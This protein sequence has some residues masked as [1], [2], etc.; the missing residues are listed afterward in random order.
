M[1]H[2]LFLAVLAVL[3]VPVLAQDPAKQEDVKLVM[4][5]K[6]ASVDAVLAYVSSKTGWIFVQEKRVS[7]TIEATSNTDVSVAS[8]LEILNTALARH[9][10]IILNPYSPR[11]PKPGEVLKVQDTDVGKRLNLEIHVGSDPDTIPIT[12]QMRTQ[13][14]PLKAVNVVEVN[15]E[16]G[17]TLRN[18]MGDGGSV[19]VTTYSNSM[20]LVGRSQGINRAVRILRV[21]DVSTSAELKIRVFPL[22]NADAA[23]TA[24]TLN[25]VFKKEAVQG[26]TGR[27]ADLGGIMRMFTGGGDGGGR[28]GRGGGSS[29]GA[30]GTRALAHE[31]VR[32]TA[33][34]RTNS[35]IVSATED[36]MKI[37]EDLI[38]KL[39]DK[40]A[41][42]VRLKLYPL[43][44]ADATAAAKLINDI[45]AETA[46][47]SSQNR[48]GRGGNQ[49][50]PIWMGGSP[51]GGS[52]DP[53]GATKEV[54]AVAEIRT[55]SVLVAASEE[56]LRIIDDLVR[57]IDRQVND[58]LIVK[59][60]ELKNA[61]PVQMTTILQSLFR[62]QV[63]ATMNSGRGGGGNTGGGGNFMQNIMGFG[64]GGG[65]R[66]GGSGAS[67]PLLP[68][69]EV[70]IT[71]DP[72]TRSI[73]VKASKEYMAIIDDVIK[74]LDANPTENVATYVVPLKNADA[75]SLAT[76][77]QNLL[78]G[79]T[80]GTGTSQFGAQNR[81]GQQGMS[82]F[83]NQNQQQQ[84]TRGNTSGFGGTRSG[85]GGSTRTGGGTRLGPL[86][87][88]DPPV[89]G[90]QEEDPR[91]P[92]T[93][94]EGQ[95]D[96]QPDPLTNSL[97]IR[98]SP[99][100]FQSIQSLLQD[101][102]RLRPQV[103][104][105]VLIADVT[106]DE[107]TQFGVE[108][109][110]ENKMRVRGGDLATN[111]LATDFALGTTGFSYL[112][113]GDEFSATLNLFAR[114]G[115]LKVLATPRILAL[116]N[117]TASINVGKEVPRISNSQINQL[118]NT[119]NTVVYENVGILLQVTPHINPDG[120]VTMDV[121]PE[122]SDVASAAESV[123]ITEGVTSPT[124]NVNAAST[125]VAVRNGTTVV[126]GGLIRESLDD[127]VDKVPF[128]GDI[129]IL[130]HLFSNTSKRK[131]K[132]ELMIF[133][134]PYVAYTQAQLEELTQLEK[135]RLKI[136][137]L[138]DV[139]AESDR[140][141]E[142]VRR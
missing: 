12:D 120:L 42:A 2:A 3:A 91:R 10:A 16:L 4:R 30:S 101:L 107:N 110:W 35:V 136:M 60:Y 34:Q 117:A 36:N 141:L 56:K 119:V 97:V 70:E 69:Q 48:G 104:I 78:R 65:N 13:I 137:D 140:W 79:S 89:P 95:A 135:S 112:L 53:L 76:T 139:E 62:P 52:S 103:L 67:S 127:S 87:P 132:R 46:T 74:Q 90:L 19:S 57:E 133:L 11:L 64:G 31:M 29:G 58:M 23:E 22:K 130:G 51:V 44:Y 134:T 81:T 61:D 111:R 94:I 8:V 50:V 66:G 45:F 7:G 5:F 39:D 142:R 129:P 9:N 55:N 102:D 24:K 32:I 75:T 105:K 54:R 83:G 126:I 27:G 72:R 41:A 25:E 15:K 82:N 14:V 21:I 98:T 33:E 131:I 124:F 43:R 59:I 99:R 114:E 28:E 138:R 92:G 71:N 93:G 6:D 18:A 26:Q 85:A 115:R 80:T 73:I 63:Q 77:L 128:F 84:G 20:V 121:A 113:T 49:G 125:T 88:Q 1:R 86:D 17:D 100:N 106:L 118:G 37:I 40:S 109:F 68:S 122:I 47:N 123:P 108:G 116:D 38:R 96:I